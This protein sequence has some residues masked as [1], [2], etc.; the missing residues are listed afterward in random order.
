MATIAEYFEL[1]RPKPVWYLGDRVSGRWNN[2]PFIGTVAVDNLVSEDLG[3][4][5]R[6][7]LDLPIK[8]EEEIHTVIIVKQDEIKRLKSI[9]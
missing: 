4:Q 3:P 9:K 7:F 1:H 8:F 2:I 6:V 5:V